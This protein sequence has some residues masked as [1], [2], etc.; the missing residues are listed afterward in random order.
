MVPRAVSQTEQPKGGRQAYRPVRFP[1]PSSA[2]VRE[3]QGMA[4]GCPFLTQTG[5]GRPFLRLRNDPEIASLSLFFSFGCFQFKSIRQ[6]TRSQNL[7]LNMPGVLIY[8]FIYLFVF[9]FFF[10]SPPSTLF[11]KLVWF[12]ISPAWLSIL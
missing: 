6:K 5:K 10:P 1:R 3:K 12:N 4:L 2:G 7:Q 8:L 9:F 11:L